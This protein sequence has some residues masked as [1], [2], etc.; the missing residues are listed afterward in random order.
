MATLLLYAVDLEE[1]RRWVGSGDA[2]LMREGMTILREDEEA[3]WEPEE[4]TLLERLLRRIVM[5][6]RL[7]DGLSSEERYYLTQLLVDLFDELLESEAVSDELPLSAV[8]SALAP[9]RNA[10][11]PAAASAYAHPG[12]GWLTHGRLFGTDEPAWDGRGDI[13]D[14]LPYFGTVTRDELPALIAALAS[15]GDGATGRRG[16]GAKEKGPSSRPV[17][18]PAPA[19]LRPSPRRE[20]R[21]RRPVSSPRVIP[22]LLTACQTALETERDLFAFVA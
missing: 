2:S 5:D 8:E 21:P 4:L 3:D 16:D 7:Y 1:M 13:D 12:A 14:V 19:S 18:P 9:L 10:G 11:G 17:A 6:G 20:E 22:Q 15:L